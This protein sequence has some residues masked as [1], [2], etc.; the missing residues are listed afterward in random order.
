MSAR[1]RPQVS[2]DGRTGSSES[3][4]T[5]AAGEEADVSSSGGAPAGSFQEA[6]NDPGQRESEEQREDRNLMELLQEFRVA[7]FV[8]PLPQRCPSVP[9]SMFDGDRRSFS[10]SM[11]R[12]RSA[13]IRLRRWPGSF[14]SWA[15]SGPTTGPPSSGAHHSTAA[16]W[17]TG[18]RSSWECSLPLRKGVGPATNPASSARHPRSSHSSQGGPDEPDPACSKTHGASD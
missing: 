2:R 12:A 10:K 3:Q 1:R 7:V 5:W 9:T 15:S 4:M 18:A 6:A 16:R 14:I 17:S 13:T 11:A 8:G